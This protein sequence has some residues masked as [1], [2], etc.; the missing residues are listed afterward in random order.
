MSIKSKILSLIGARWIGAPLRFVGAMTRRRSHITGLINP[1]HVSSTTVENAGAHYI[2]YPNS[3]LAEAV[4]FKGAMRFPPDEFEPEVSFLAEK[5]I[6]E[7]D[8]VLDIGANAGLH[9]V[10]FAR[11]TNAGHVYAFEPV[12]EMVERLSENCALNRVE[13]VTII[14]CA[15]GA[16]SEMLEMDVNVSGVGLE[17]TSSLAQSFHVEDHP[18]N[19]EGRTVPVRR[20]DDIIEKLKID[21]RIAFVKIDTEG[22]ET[23]VIEGGMKTLEKHR[24]AMIVEAHSRRLAKAGKSFQWYLDTFADYHI[25]VMPAVDRAN[26]YFRLVPLTAEQPEIAV[27][28]LLLPRS[29]A[30]IDVELD[31]RDT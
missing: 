25:F 26:P 7:N 14:R 12:A 16:R 15:L 13:N 17:G 8:V 22:F 24:P 5:L 6:R 23:Y 18:E 9:T 29:L 11:A 1:F 30:E 3:Y 2:A 20:L 28:L 27:N 31:T 10:T 4:G 21:Q 19:Y